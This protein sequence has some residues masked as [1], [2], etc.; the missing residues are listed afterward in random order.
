MSDTFVV[1]PEIA[2]EMEFESIC[3]SVTGRSVYTCLPRETKLNGQVL[4]DASEQFNYLGD[5]LEN[6]DSIYYGESKEARNFLRY[7][8][9]KLNRGAMIVSTW[10]VIDPNKKDKVIFAIGGR[11]RE[12]KTDHRRGDPD[13]N[14]F[15][16][17]DKSK[18]ER[19]IELV[20][21]NPDLLEKFYQ[22]TFADLDSKPDIDTGLRRIK[23]DDLW[24]LNLRDEYPLESAVKL[25]FSTKVGVRD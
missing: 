12:G 7:T 1:N 3:D 24:I 16:E 2:Q 14:L 8:D 19:L 4:K 11:Q 23:T 10:D 21:D 20:K 9:P 17:M 6:S 5:G 15:V 25:K 13:Y 18:A 22:N